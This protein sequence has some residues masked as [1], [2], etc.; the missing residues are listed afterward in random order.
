MKVQPQ[1]IRTPRGCL[2]GWKAVTR[3]RY[4]IYR[5][6]IRHPK[7]KYDPDTVHIADS[8]GLVTFGEYRSAKELARRRSC[9]SRECMPGIHLY[10]TLEAA[11]RWATFALKSG[12]AYH[13]KIIPVAFSPK[14]IVGKKCDGTIVVYR[15][16]VLG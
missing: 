9:Q 3:K 14:S 6:G 13:L 15:I 1:T 4:P 16:K 7:D 5:R 2:V 8:D 10:K 11:K 12:N